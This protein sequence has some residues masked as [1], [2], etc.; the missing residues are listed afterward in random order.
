MA[1]AAQE[2][3]IKLVEQ[4]SATRSQ[5]DRMVLRESA[6]KGERLGGGESS[7]ELRREKRGANAMLI[8]TQR[9][10]AEQRRQVEEQIAR[11]EKA[12]QS[13]NPHA[14]LDDMQQEGAEGSGGAVGYEEALRVQ[15]QLDGL[16]RKL[17]DLEREQVDGNWS[18][19]EGLVSLS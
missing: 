11:L 14:R 15:M 9:K 13:A 16:R 7:A 4:L 2:R 8:E 10:V 5:L 19:A 1:G 18:V 12:Q 6:D 3:L 17:N